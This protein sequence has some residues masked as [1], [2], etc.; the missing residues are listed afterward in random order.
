LRVVATLRVADLI[1]EGK[2]DVAEIAKAAGADAESLQRVMRLLVAKGIFEEPEPGRFALNDTAR[3]LLGEG[4]V[5]F[6]LHG[7]GSRL[8][9]VWNTLLS[10]VITGKPAY[11]EAFG[12]PYWEDLEANPKIAREFD[13][14]MGPGHGKRN[15]DVLF[16]AADW[17]SIRTV[18]D[19]GGGTGSL[20][21]EVLRAHPHLRGFLVDLP[22]TVERAIQHERMTPVGQ[23]FFDPLPAGKDL[24]MMDRVLNDWPD[25]G[26][27]RILTRIAEALPPAGR[28]MVLAGVSGRAKA[29]PELLM[30]VLVG[31]KDRTLEEFRA[32][33]ERAGLRV[34]NA[35]VLR[36]GRFAVE[37]RTR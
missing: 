4:R 10:A 14:L 37:C 34:S 13:L 8:A 19:V 32:L 3:G 24:Y 17:G 18:V 16:D 6:D 29:S 2:S 15:P 28:L 23:S 31:G 30:M 22:R 20:L 35:G 27:L 26:A 5:G 21:V 36:S 9:G 12:K 33:A 11:H 1:A 25:A 7:F